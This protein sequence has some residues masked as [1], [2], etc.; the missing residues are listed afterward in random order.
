[1]AVPKRKHSRSRTNKRRS[2]WR[3][4]ATPGLVECP[5][6]HE[7]KRPHRVCP[8]CGYYKDRMVLEKE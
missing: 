6:C 4:L 5:R 8:E 3:Q 1:M 2:I 7:L